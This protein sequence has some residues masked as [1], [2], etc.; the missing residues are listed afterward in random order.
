MNRSDESI[1]RIGASSCLLGEKVRHDAGHKKDAYITDVLQEY[2][3]FV[4]V[5]PEM[6]V[7]MG[8]P[9]ETVRLE[10]SVD[11]P[12]IVGTESGAEWTDRMRHYAEERTRKLETEN[13]CGYILKKD[14]PSCGMERVRVYQKGVPSRIGRGLYAETLISRFPL[15]PVEEEGRLNDSKIRENF[16]VR[17]FAYHR[18]RQVCRGRFSRKALIQFH[19]DHKFLLLSHSPKH[20]Q[21]L[22][23]LVA[24]ISEYNDS[25]FCAKYGALFMENLKIKSTPS[26]NANVLQHILGFLREHLESDDRK[27]ILDVIEDYRLGLVP[28]VVPITLIKHYVIKFNVSYIA[29]QIYLNPHPKELMLRNHI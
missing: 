16:I 12:R 29:D 4:S 27:Y 5:C 23:Q 28:L 10:G 9:R 25:E 21:Q 15:L 19:T 3:R 6:G 18:L 24:H 7:G 1:I 26:K 13:L 2:F 22:G 11:S 14:S 20:Y 8:V 17:V